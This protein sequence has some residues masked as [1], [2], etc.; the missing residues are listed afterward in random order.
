MSAQGKLEF[1]EWLKVRDTV[2]AVL[3]EYVASPNSK[4]AEEL[5]AAGLIDIAAI[6]GED[7]SVEDEKP[8]W[9]P[10]HLW[11]RTAQSEPIEIRLLA[12]AGDSHLSRVESESGQIYS[13]PDHRLQQLKEIQS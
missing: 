10:T 12:P 6:L 9:T 5:M 13:V 3:S 2:E 11:Y 1:A 7:E 8:A 4:I